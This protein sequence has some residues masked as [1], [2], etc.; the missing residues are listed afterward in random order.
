[1][2]K[3]KAKALMKADATI[4]PNDVLQKTIH[5][6]PA[7]VRSYLPNN[8]ALEIQL[9]RSRSR[10][11]RFNEPHSLADLFILSKYRETLKGEKCLFYGSR[12]QNQ[13]LIFTTRHNLEV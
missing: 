9:Y 11:Y 8:K 10:E 13:I 6:L 1:L 2:A 5:K 7:E 4:C 3:A 12:D